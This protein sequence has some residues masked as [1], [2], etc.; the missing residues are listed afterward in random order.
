MT[1]LRSLSIKNDK[2]FFAENEELPN[3]GVDNS[4]PVLQQLLETKDADLGMRAKRLACS[5][6]GLQCGCCQRIYVRRIKFNE[7]CKR[8]HQLKT[9]LLNLNRN[10]NFFLADI[11]ILRYCCMMMMQKL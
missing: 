1:S 10:M 9:N 7:N 3:E 4:S 11:N 5:C 2:Y 8:C 6:S